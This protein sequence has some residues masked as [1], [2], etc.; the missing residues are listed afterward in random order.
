[1]VA[2][3]GH[4]PKK[5]KNPISIPMNA[6]FVESILANPRQ[7]QYVISAWEES[8]CTWPKALKNALSDRGIS[9]G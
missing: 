1:M 8:Y 2:K 5:G 3:N 7:N 6:D 9:I 4:K